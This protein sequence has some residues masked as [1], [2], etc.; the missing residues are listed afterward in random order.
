MSCVYAGEM[1]SPKNRELIG[2]SYGLAT[3]VGAELEI[4]VSLFGDY[5]L[6]ALF[7]LVASALALGAAYFM[8]E[9]PYYLVGRGDDERALRNLRYLQNE[10]SDAEALAELHAVKEYVD[11][12][13]NE[14]WQPNDCEIVLQPKN[15]RLTLLMIVLNG[16]SAMNCANLIPQTGSFILKD[17]QVMAKWLKPRGSR[18]ERIPHNTGVSP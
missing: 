17:F 16:L 7:P 5:R 6:L 18:L 12:Q 11:E 8:V 9:S 13:K 3:M 15:L 1:S 14:R 10:A 4:L 2:T